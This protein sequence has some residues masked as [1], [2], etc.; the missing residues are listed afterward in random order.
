VGQLQDVLKIQNA[1]VTKITYSIY[2][3]TKILKPH[4]AD[5]CQVCNNN[6]KSGNSLHVY[7]ICYALV[8]LHAL[9]HLIL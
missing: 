3:H 6:K 8:T 7:V 1:T 9:M 4:M 2:A 5:F